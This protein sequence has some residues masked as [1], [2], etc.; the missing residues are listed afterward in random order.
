MSS[1]SK[2][3]E[4]YI[5][6]HEDVVVYVGSGKMGRHKHCVSGVS[7]CYGLN[8]LHFTE[9]E[10]V[11]VDVIALFQDKKESLDYEK[12]LIMLHKP[13]FNTIFNKDVMN[14]LVNRSKGLR[15]R[16][17][18]LAVDEDVSDIN[19]EKFKNLLSEFFNFYSFSDVE[20]GNITIY[21]GT[22][23][24]KMGMIHMAQ[25]TRFLREGND[26]YRDKHFC[27]V[28]YKVSKILLGYDIINSLCKTQKLN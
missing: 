8:K 14:D 1:K 18:N 11:H 3:Y 26:F 2:I 17:I 5:C 21:T 4:V 10:K 13:I 6:K 22:F 25:L 20:S 15:N 23:Y 24:K 19:L 27:V 16:F 7:H 28:F 9:S 12:S